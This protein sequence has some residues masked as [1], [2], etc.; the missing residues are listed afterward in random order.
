MSKN[1][2]VET[3]REKHV[4]RTISAELAIYGD[5]KFKKSCFFK[6]NQILC[7]KFSCFLFWLEKGLVIAVGKWRAGGGG[8]VMVF[9]AKE[10]K[11]LVGIGGKFQVKLSLEV[12]LKLSLEVS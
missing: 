7:D 6:L 8:G 3:E 4:S 1:Y 5:Y 12:S 10:N 9:V 11:W 2:C